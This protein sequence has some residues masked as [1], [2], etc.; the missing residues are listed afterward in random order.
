MHSHYEWIAN[1]R[2]RYYRPLHA[3][4]SLLRRVAGSSIDGNLS[5]Y[6]EMVERAKAFNFSGL[7]ASQLAARMPQLAGSIRTRNGHEDMDSQG[8]NESGEGGAE[9]PS[10]GIEAEACALVREASR[11][12]LRLD[13]FDAQMIAGMAMAR[14]CIAELPTGEGK[15]LAAVFTACLR[16]LPGRGAHVLTFNDYLARRDATWM[17]PVYGALGLSVGYIQEGMSLREKR[18]AYACDVT[19]AS[20]KEA[21]F[22]FLRDQTAFDRASLVHRPLHFAL[23]DEADSILID[24]AR[25][26]L[27]IAGAEDRVTWD[28]DRLASI[29]K[30]LIPERDFATDAEHRN[31]FLTD[32]GIESVESMLGCGSLY[33]ACNQSL[34]Q[35]VYCALH[36]R[37]LLRRDVD[38]IVRR[39]RIEIVD[40]Y[41]GRVVNKRHWPDGLQAAVE[42]KEGLFPKT[43]GRV[44]GSITLQHFFNLYPA[45]C[46]MTATAQSAADEFYEFYG[47]K[48]AIIPPHTPSMR[49][50]HPDL[51]FV[52]RDAKLQ[53]IVREIGNAHALER[54][55]LVGTANVKESEEI[56]AGLRSAGIPCMVLNAKNDEL[57]A[58]VIAKAGMLG[59]VTISTNMA[60]RG[61]DIRLGGDDPSHHDAVGALGG[62]YV[63]GTNRHESLRIDHQ[64][65]GRAGRQG[66]PGATRFIISLEDD[67]FEHYGLTKTLMAQHRSSPGDEALPGGSIRREI[68][69]AQRIIEGQNFGIRRFICKFSSLVE[70]QRQIVQAR[71]EINLLGAEAPERGS[72]LSNGCSGISTGHVTD[73]VDCRE[74]AESEEGGGASTTFA[75]R[76][77]VIYEE[78]LRCFGPNK[79]AEIERRATLFHLDRLWS[80]YLAWVQDT[81]D[82]IHLVNLGGREPL[83]EFRRWA[84]AEF[85]RMQNAID[86]AVADEMTAVIRKDGPIDLDVERLTGPSSTWTYMVN[87]N[88]FGWGVD[89]AKSQNIGFVRMAFLGPGAIVTAPLLLLT[90]LLKGCRRRGQR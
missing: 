84:T 55:V 4:K 15:T 33:A 54:P 70:L 17:G 37:A 64:L 35:S 48:V 42:A 25:I 14:G 61:V 28:T 65:R 76:M 34:L 75:R 50:D 12:T 82:S 7:S 19:Y 6:R 29:V 89:M 36:A 60:G 39:G 78:G 86:E 87:E 77:P 21:G 30:G 43:Q 10:P 52:H 79:M 27:V 67:L 85:L 74:P 51:V 11:R 71:R 1:A 73:E 20:A 16:S 72:V 46:G 88:Q 24:E 2:F 32:A 66:D 56:A 59:S 31:V 9:F 41:T 63:I 18:A 3:V 44:L 62:L 40:E 8:F 58:S 49:V 45:V 47:A 57:E 23:V 80:D 26:P 38:Y 69:H 81:R 22:D 53:A 83:D 68:A 90:L 13:P 5:E